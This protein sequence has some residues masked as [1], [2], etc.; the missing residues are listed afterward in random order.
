M[1]AEMDALRYAKDGDTLKVIR[2]LKNGTPTMAKPCKFC[3][4]LIKKYNL[5]SVQYTNW[6]GKWEEVK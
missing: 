3:L 6:D 1:H 5:E 4:K 2:F